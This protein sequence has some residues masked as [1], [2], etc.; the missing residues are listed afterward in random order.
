MHT[1]GAG[2]V[3]VCVLQR[4]CLRV[5]VALALEVFLQRCKHSLDTVFEEYCCKGGDNPKDLLIYYGV[6][7]S[8]RC[9]A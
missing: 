8:V 1:F 3:C 5:Y 9:A 7:V 6:L 2:C 4:V